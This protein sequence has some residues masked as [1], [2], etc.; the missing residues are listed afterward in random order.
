MSDKK[1]KK[2]HSLYLQM[3]V[4]FWAI[5]CCCCC[6][7]VAKSYSILC[8]PINCSTPGFPVLHHLLELAQT[9]VYWV[10]FVIQPSHCHPPLFLPSIF[11]KIFSN[12]SALSIRS[13]K[14]WSFIFGIIL[15]M[16]IQS[17]FSLGLIVLTSLECKGLSRDFST[18][19]STLVFSLL[20]GPSLISIHDYSKNHSLTKQTLIFHFFKFHGFSNC[21][22]WGDF[23][24]QGNKIFF[25]YFPFYLTWI[26]G[27]RC[28]D[29]SFWNVEFQAKFSILFFQ[30]HQ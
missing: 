3:T 29:L 9:H 2:K 1:L 16:N 22:W 21:P 10:D 11:P 27:T 20:F 7:S 13:P 24:A 17:W 8:G 30:P 28:Q 26:D 12:E 18:S 25:Q 14:Y 23:R 15:P 5:S 19:I 6:C 4:T